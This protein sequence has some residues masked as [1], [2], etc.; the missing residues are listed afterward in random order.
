VKVR[1][2]AYCN[3][4]TKIYNDIMSEY[5]VGVG[6]AYLVTSSRLKGAQLNEQFTPFAMLGW[7]AENW[8]IEE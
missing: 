3:I 7:D 2:E 4:A 5:V 1:Q 8:Y 6:A